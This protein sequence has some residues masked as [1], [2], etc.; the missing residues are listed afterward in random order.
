MTPNFSYIFYLTQNAL[1]ILYFL[2]REYDTAINLFQNAL[3]LDPTNYLL[4]NKIGAAMA[5]L[6][7]AD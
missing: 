5:H 7:R 3:Q 1:A 6:G 2:K 4:M